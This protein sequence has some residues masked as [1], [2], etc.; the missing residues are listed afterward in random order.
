V[1][2]TWNLLKGI[3]LTAIFPLQVDGSELAFRLMGRAY[4]VQLAY[5]PMLISKLLAQPKHLLKYMHFSTND[6]DSPLIVQICGND[7]EIVAAACRRVEPYCEAIDLNLGCPQRVAKRGN[8]GSFLLDKP[9]LVYSLVTAMNNAVEVPIFCKM[10]I[11][12]SLE[13]TIDFA[14]YRTIKHINYWLPC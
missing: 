2:H 14:R 13:Q 9:D 12:D 11:K 10:R 5:S 4:G 8:Y 1:Q 6:R 7:P 3:A